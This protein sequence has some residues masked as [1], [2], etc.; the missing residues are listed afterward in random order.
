M[1][2]LLSILG[3]VLKLGRSPEALRGRL[4]Y[5]LARVADLQHLL[6][7]E[8]NK[9]VKRRKRRLAYW[10]GRVDTL[11]DRLGDG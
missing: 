10:Q 3:Q 4:S 1:T 5:A 9:R 11:M 8:P 6:E 2:E 7:E